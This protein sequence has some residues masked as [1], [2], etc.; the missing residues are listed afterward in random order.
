[1]VQSK[2]ICLGRK[3]NILFNSFD[4]SVKSLSKIL[5][6][7]ERNDYGDRLYSMPGCDYIIRSLHLFDLYR[8]PVLI[9]NITQNANFSFLLG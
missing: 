7:D 6:E 1:M 9:Y 3:E 2:T 5:M 8:R 4:D